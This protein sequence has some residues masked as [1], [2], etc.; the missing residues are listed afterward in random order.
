MESKIG[1]L[2]AGW[3]PAI[4]RVLIGACIAF[5]AAGVNAAGTAFGKSLENAGADPQLVN[6]A[7]AAWNLGSTLSAGSRAAPNPFAPVASLF[8]DGMSFA[9]NVLTMRGNVVLLD[10]VL[11]RHDAEGNEDRIAKIDDATKVAQYLLPKLHELCERL[12]GQ[13]TNAVPSGNPGESEPED[14]PEHEDGEQEPPGPW[15]AGDALCAEKCAKAWWNFTYLKRRNESIAALLQEHAGIAALLGRVIAASRAEL[16]RHEA[17]AA[18]AVPTMT[19]TAD[20]EAIRTVQRREAARRAAALVRARIQTYQSRL[21]ATN[22]EIARLRTL[23]AFNAAQAD[24]AYAAYLACLMDCWSK[25]VNETQA[26]AN[27]IESATRRNADDAG[28]AQ[29]N[30]LIGEF[31]LNPGEFNCRV[32]RAIVLTPGDAA[33]ADLNDDGENEVLVL[34]AAGGELTVLFGVDR[35]AGLPETVRYALGG[36]ALSVGVFDADG[37]CV[38][39]L[40]SAHAGWPDADAL[41][42]GADVSEV[43]TRV[44]FGFGNGYFEPTPSGP[45]EEVRFDQTPVEPA[46]GTLIPTLPAPAPTLAPTSAG[47][48]PVREDVLIGIEPTALEPASLVPVLQ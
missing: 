14:T 42:E 22:R 41:F 48:L 6:A 23:H 9:C 25:I 3:Q 33:Q 44:W 46:D 11:K 26:R 24:E 13:P 16:A 10:L 18:V 40:V 15:D 27:A 1:R 43:E 47:Q 35:T 7:D 29:R 19:S 5:A 45:M 12:A 8:L 21:D 36:G 32:E 17:A 37:D 2:G 39:D 38:V 34:D 20:V 28:Q 30:R 4:G 31:F